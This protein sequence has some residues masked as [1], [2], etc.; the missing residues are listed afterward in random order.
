MREAIYLPIERARTPLRQAFTSE[1][2]AEAESDCVF[3]RNW[4]ALCFTELV[5]EVGD[6]LPVD[7]AGMC[8][9]C[10]LASSPTWCI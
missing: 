5:S 6:V 8:Q 1:A 3:A 4:S 10:I 2:F 7:L 9:T